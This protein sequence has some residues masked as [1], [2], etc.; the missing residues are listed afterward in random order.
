MSAET[1]RILDVNAKAEEEYQY[2]KNELLGMTFADL[3][4][5]TDREETLK[6]IQQL[7]EGDIT[8]LPLLKHRRKD[9]SIFMVNYQ[10]GLSRYLDQ[11]AVIA[12]VW[13]VTERLEKYA[14]LIQ[15]GKMATLGEMATGIAH[16][17][18]QPLNVLKL[19]CDYIMKKIRGG[20]DISTDEL[21]QITRECNSSV[22][23]ASLIINHLRQF[24]RRAEETMSPVDINQ[25]IQNVFNL[26]GRQLEAR[27]ITWD[28]VLT[29]DLP[30]ILGDTNRLEQV[31]INLI[32]N[33]RDAILSA[34]ESSVTDPRIEIR[35]LLLDGRVTVKVSDT[36]PGV[37]ECAK[38]KVFE[39][40]FTTKKPGEG[41]GLGLSISYGIIKEHQG[42]IE[43]AGKVDCG[44]T[45]ILTFPA[46][47][48]EAK[49]D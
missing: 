30:K 3:G 8:F 20:Y 2:S 18:N 16:E 38:T 40:F 39:P 48:P 45:F 19:S 12:A 9:G 49:D 26:L 47:E 42:T 46:L 5:D 21:S 31:M 43:I 6:G 13:D 37:P 41:T 32:L 34:G 27:G 29:N 15:A 25:P 35:S 10:A 4:L 22:D 28:L 36:G 14:Q 23:R 1:L 44:A 24:G 33:A 17:L 7:F 11:P